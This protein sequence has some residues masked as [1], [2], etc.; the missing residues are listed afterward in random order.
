[1][2]AAELLIQPTTVTDLVNS[3]TKDSDEVDGGGGDDGQET[4]HM[5]LVRLV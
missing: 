2:S 1:M 4:N 5:N 3:S